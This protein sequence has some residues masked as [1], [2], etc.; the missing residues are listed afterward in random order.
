MAPCVSVCLPVYN[1]ERYLAGA[2]ESVLRQSLTDFELIIADNASTDGTG[3]LCR[4]AASRDS[5]IRYLSAERNGGLAWNFN[6]AFRASRGRY[7]VW[8]ATDD[9][10]APEFLRRCVDALEADPTAVV[11]FCNRNDIDAQGVTRAQLTLTNPGSS[12]SPFQRLKDIIAEEMCEP[13]WG[14]M[15]ADALRQTRLHQG[16]ADSDRVLLVEMGLRGTFRKLD[17]VL[18]S[19]RGHSGSVTAT[20]DRWA[21]TV[22]FDPSKAGKMICPWWLELFALA[23]A[24]WR[25]PL[26]RRERFEMLKYIY[27]WG[28]ARQR[29]LIADLRRAW[30]VLIGGI[31]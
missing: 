6:R 25:A 21:R 31:S 29:L 26:P 11:C 8:L 30:C 1:G 20:E 28:R 10:I 3:P 7:V 5:R 19:R 18:F 9:V 14:L 16:F 22:I 13:V 27:W 15:R 2:I 24:V 4:E 23:S 12:G 17:E